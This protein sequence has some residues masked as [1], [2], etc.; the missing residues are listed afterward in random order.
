MVLTVYGT[1]WPILCW[2]AV[3]KLLTHFTPA[4]AIIRSASPLECNVLIPW[5]WSFSER[6]LMNFDRLRWVTY[7][8]EASASYPSKTTTGFANWFTYFY[9]EAV[10]SKVSPFFHGN[11]CRRE[12]PSRTLYTGWQAL[13]CLLHYDGWLDDSALATSGSF[14]RRRRPCLSNNA[15]GCDESSYFILS[16]ML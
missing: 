11:L 1:E 7:F 14:A 6:K 8:V 10:E 16:F 13:D 5:V 4:N 2:C 15:V 9:V 12:P 3:K